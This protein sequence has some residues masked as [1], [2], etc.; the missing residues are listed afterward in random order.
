MFQVSQKCPILWIKQEWVGKLCDVHNKVEDAGVLADWD[1]WQK[2]P[3][4]KPEV[5]ECDAEFPWFQ[6]LFSRGQQEEK[7]IHMAHDNGLANVPSNEINGNFITPGES[8]EDVN[9]TQSADSDNE[10]E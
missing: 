3:I 1:L 2:I 6:K 10:L 9:S 7:V 8:V 5:D 4:Q